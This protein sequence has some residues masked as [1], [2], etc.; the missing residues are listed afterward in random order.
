[1]RMNNKKYLARF[2]RVCR[3]MSLQFQAG[4]SG[5]G[6]RPALSLIDRHDTNPLSQTRRVL[7]KDP[8]LLALHILDRTACT[9]SRPA[10]PVARHLVKYINGTFY[11]SRCAVRGFVRTHFLPFTRS[12]RESRT[13]LHLLNLWN[14]SIVDSIHIFCQFDVDFFLLRAA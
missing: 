12:D 13:T 6:A 11:A 14:E 3:A 4:P 9:F 8:Y 5:Q 2:V 10:S 7:R 1:M